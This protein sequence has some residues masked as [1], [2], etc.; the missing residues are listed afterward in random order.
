MEQREHFCVGQNRPSTRPVVYPQGHPP[1]HRRGWCPAQTKI[2]TELWCKKW[3]KF[4][5]ALLDCDQSALFHTSAALCIGLGLG[6]GPRGSEGELGWHSSKLLKQ[7]SGT[8]PFLFLMPRSAPL[9]ARKQAMLALDF[10]SA[11]W[12][13]RPINSFPTSWAQ[14]KLDWYHHN[15]YQDSTCMSCS[16][17]SWDRVWCLRLSCRGVSPSLSVMFRLAPS[18]TCHG[19]HSLLCHHTHIDIDQY[20][21]CTDLILLT[22]PIARGIL[23]LMKVGISTST[24]FQVVPFCSLISKQLLF[25]L[26]DN[27]LRR[28]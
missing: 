19:G 3:K 12:L 22:S 5:P 17:L 10:L 9:A 8:W 20:Y 11:P 14:C 1:C 7:L 16:C 21:T 13:P 2:R 25:S 23:I 15:W 26:S 27:F 24:W 18:L 6:K 28:L 4:S